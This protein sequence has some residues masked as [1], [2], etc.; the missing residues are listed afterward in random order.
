MLLA[1]GQTKVGAFGKPLSGDSS[2]ELR[3]NTLK[4][5]VLCE[6]RRFAASIHTYTTKR[7]QNNNLWTRKCILKIYYI[8]CLSGTVYVYKFSR[9]VAKEHKKQKCHRQRHFHV[10]NFYI[11]AKSWWYFCRIFGIFCSTLYILQANLYHYLLVP[12]ETGMQSLLWIQK[13]A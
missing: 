1:K 6:S 2:R 8:K 9:K 13:I 3:L 4:S 11:V 5:I 12:M 10:Y 7:L